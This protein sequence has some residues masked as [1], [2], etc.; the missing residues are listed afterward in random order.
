MWARIRSFLIMG[1]LFLLK[2]FIVLVVLFLPF[3]IYWGWQESKAIEQC[4][5]QGKQYNEC[6]ELYNW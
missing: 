6:Y 1:L 4:M 3:A 5:Q 2:V